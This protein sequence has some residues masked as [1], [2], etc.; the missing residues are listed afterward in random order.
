VNG[1]LD[2]SGGFAWTGLVYVAGDV[3][4]TGNA[5]VLG[6]MLVMGQS[7]VGFGGGNP[8]ILYSRDAIRLALELAFD[9]II[10]SWKEL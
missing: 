1:D 9:Y 3:R 10:I 5:W 2:I 6:A 7:D 8:S 4:I